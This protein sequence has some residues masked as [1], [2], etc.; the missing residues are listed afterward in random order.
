MQVVLNNVQNRDKGK[1]G[2]LTGVLI[3]TLVKCKLA[4]R[5]KV[6]C[7]SLDHSSGV[8]LLQ[9][10][11]LMQNLQE[12]ILYKTYQKSITDIEGYTVLIK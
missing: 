5:I 10:Q 2:S 4:E 6:L 12:E 8:M 1:F 7:I 11:Q 9:L 3:K